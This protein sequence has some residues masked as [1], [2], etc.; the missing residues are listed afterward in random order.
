M[1]KIGGT[2]VMD[3]H[4]FQ[5][6][7]PNVAIKKSGNWEVTLSRHPMLNQLGR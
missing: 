1:K 6:Q 2:E 4:I 3:T 7:C 5:A